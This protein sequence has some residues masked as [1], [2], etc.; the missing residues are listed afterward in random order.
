MR[1]SSWWRK[2]DGQDRIPSHWRR[3]KSL[4]G[5]RNR[6]GEEENGMV[7]LGE[8]KLGDGPRRTMVEDGPIWHAQR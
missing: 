7:G 1:L 8:E 3:Q 6:R 2:G 5:G 4:R